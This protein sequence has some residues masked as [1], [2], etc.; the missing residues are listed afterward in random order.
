MVR[1]N[2]NVPVLIKEL[3]KNYPKVRCALHHHNPLQLLVATILSA[4]CTDE[5]VNKVTPPLFEKYKKLAVRYFCL[6][7]T[8]VW[9]LSY[10]GFEETH[11][12]PQIGILVE[13]NCIVK[14][15]VPRIETYYEHVSN[16]FRVSE[17]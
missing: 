13:S 12:F 1:L 14:E 8:L 11:F 9:N 16:E 17:I 7:S 4:Q 6:S 10:R 5:R 3:K 2:K 15:R